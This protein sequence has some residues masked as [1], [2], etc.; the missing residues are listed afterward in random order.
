M[1]EQAGHQLT[2]PLTG[3]PPSCLLRTGREPR[4]CRPDQT[5]PPS[6]TDALQ[7]EP[8]APSPGPGRPQHGAQIS[9][10]STAHWTVA[11]RMPAPPRVRVPTADTGDLT[12]PKVSG[13]EPGAG[14]LGEGGD[15]RPPRGWT[16]R[17]AATLWE[18]MMFTAWHSYWPWS[19]RATAEIL[20]VPDDRTRWRLSTDS[21]LPA[22]RGRALSDMDAGAGAWPSPGRQMQPRGQ[23]EARLTDGRIEQLAVPRSSPEPP[24]PRPAALVLSE[25]RS[26]WT[27]HAL[28][29]VLIPLLW[30]A[31]GTV[32]Q[33][34]RGGSVGH[35]PG[36]HSPPFVQAMT[37]CG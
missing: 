10:A 26:T 29:H 2:A 31:Q 28:G 13:C 11:A 14:P 20:S 22:R 24:A 34:A 27:C 23:A 4:A 36:G 1:R 15:H 8:P 21:W 19:C 32:P 30:P 37:G 17:W 7:A 18:P 5:R 16:A 3:Q 25:D 33:G 12:M 35:C 6:P 9:S